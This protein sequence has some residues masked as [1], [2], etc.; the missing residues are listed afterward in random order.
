MSVFTVVGDDELRHWLLQ[1]DLQLISFEG[2]A[3]GVTNTNYFVDTTHGRF[4]LTLFETLKLDEL[5]FYLHL[6]SHLARHGVACPAPLQDR[7][8]RFASLLAGRPACLVSCLHGADVEA[9]S[10]AQCRAVGD[11]QATMHKVSSSFTLR[12]DNPRGPRWWAATAAGLYR[13]MPAA[14]AELL[15]EEVHF[16]SQYRFSHLPVGV[17]HADLF[18]DNVLLDGDAITGFIDFYYACNDILLYDVA[19]AVNDWARQVDG[20]I[21]G[22]RARA[23]LDGYRAVRPLSA[24][25]AEAW[26]V[27]LRAGAL[28]FWVSRLLDLYQPMPGALTYTKDPGVFRDLLLAH[29]TRSDFWL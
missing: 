11:M 20:S 28:R 18:K 9:P 3:A 8:D 29:R 2:I 22:A 21:D 1:Y 5:P 13:F 26:P 19:I 27:M 23:F 15:R 24:A 7:Q 25:E 12:M 14:E 4:V 16:Q 10:V 6:M 17:V